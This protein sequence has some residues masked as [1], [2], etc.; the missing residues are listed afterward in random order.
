[1]CQDYCI[2]ASSKSTNTNTIR[3]CGISASDLIRTKM[4]DADTVKHIP[5][6]IAITAWNDARIEMLKVMWGQGHPDS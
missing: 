5:A 3:N 2:M 6:K 4:T 1:M